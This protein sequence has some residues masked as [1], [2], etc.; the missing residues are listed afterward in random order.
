[1]KE[2]IQTQNKWVY[3]HIRKE[4]ELNL[5]SINKAK[6]KQHEDKRKRRD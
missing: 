3:E 5:R 6:E 1:M 4:K 2:M